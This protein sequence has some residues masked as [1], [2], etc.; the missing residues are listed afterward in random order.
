[1]SSSSVLSPT[2]AAIDTAEGCSVASGGDSRCAYRFCA[3]TAAYVAIMVSS[4]AT[5]FEVLV[6]AIGATSIMSSLN[7]DEI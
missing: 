1:M 3:T 7:E 5:V 2:V 6:T 4:N